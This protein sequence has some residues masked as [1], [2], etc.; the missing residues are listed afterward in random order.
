MAERPPKEIVIEKTASNEEQL[1]IFEKLISHMKD[2]NNTQNKLLTDLLASVLNKVE[3][4]SK[5]T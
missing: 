3:E 1:K 5:G 2:E 4:R